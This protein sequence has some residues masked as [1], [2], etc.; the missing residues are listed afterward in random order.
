MRLQNQ[1]F[2]DI[3]RRKEALITEMY[4]SEKDLQIDARRYA[5][6]LNEMAGE[7]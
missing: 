1:K 3:V 2:A 6:S 4:L 7:V 5:Q